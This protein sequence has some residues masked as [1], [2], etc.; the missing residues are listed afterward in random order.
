MRTR[1]N[2]AQSQ[3]FCN[4][5]FSSAD[6]R[7][8]PHDL[9]QGATNMSI[10][11][12]EAARE[13]SRFSL[14]SFFV[15]EQEPNRAKTVP[16]SASSQRYCPVTTARTN[17]VV[18]PTIASAP[19]V[20]AAGPGLGAPVRSPATLATAAPFATPQ[21][22][23]R[24]PAQVNPGRFTFGSIVGGPSPASGRVPGADAP[25]RPQLSNTAVEAMRKLAEMQ[26]RS[27]L[28]A[29]TAQT[30]QT[31]QSM[32]GPHV[33]SQHSR[34]LAP[35]FVSGGT[36]SA[37]SGAEVMRLTAQVENMNQKLR[38]Q[39]EKLNRTEASL[40]NA[41]K[42]RE[43]ERMQNN[44][45]MANARAKINELMQNEQKLNKCCEE[46]TARLKQQTPKSISSTGDTFESAAKRAEKYDEELS[47]WK[48]K[49]ELLSSKNADLELKI[50]TT[51]KN[52][53]DAKIG[54]ELREKELTETVATATLAKEAAEQL[55]EM[56]AKNLN[57][58]DT[59]IS[60]LRQ[61]LA[62]CEFLNSNTEADD[63]STTA[64]DSLSTQTDASAIQEIEL[65]TLKT[66][67]ST[68]QEQLERTNSEHK[69][70]LEKFDG[71]N[72]KLRDALMA[73]E[74]AVQNAEAVEFD[75]DVKL[76][77]MDARLQESQKQLS[78]ATDQLALLQTVSHVPTKH[79][80]EVRDHHDLHTGCCHSK[81]EYRADEN[82][83]DG[84]D[85]DASVEGGATSA[86]TSVQTSAH[87]QD[88]QI[89]RVVPRRAM[90]ADAC[91]PFLQS[92]RA[93][94]RI[95][96]HEVGIGAH[97]EQEQMKH[98]LKSVSAD[99]TS[100]AIQMRTRYLKNMGYGEEE[101][102]EKMK[103]FEQQ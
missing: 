3:R 53:T 24:A 44:S 65:Q 26:R 73:S 8:T 32:P 69:N 49:V 17:S 60:E 45:N 75:C 43:Q 70:E 98:I 55:A 22:V 87:L 37:E 42:L 40:V 6:P 50:E 96:D 85:D 79:S 10:R 99:I 78:D 2:A 46:L 19:K 39:D 90:L 27:Q 28:D 36:L 51:T 83:E 102:L 9:A 97:D 57:K 74:S 88:A 4:R 95:H 30:A 67:V 100:A 94:F 91:V 72:D 76:K 103:E 54:F 25:S 56:A 92:A 80:F 31:F 38:M 21:V 62:E 13:A 29:Q 16:T 12:E 1:A 33:N 7:G 58:Q 101:I 34:M 35:G 59:E 81:C 86:Q 77:D 82:D 23:Q 48:D 5:C 66:T 89:Y 63:Q 20:V 71:I 52:A 61:K 18:A 84:S 47:A 15:Q 14:R 41:N 64:M 93:T 68:L 11:A